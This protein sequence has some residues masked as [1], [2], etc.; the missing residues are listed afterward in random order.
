MDDFFVSLKNDGTSNSSRNTI[1]LPRSFE[2]YEF[3][4]MKVK[5]REILNSWLNLNPQLRLKK[6][7]NGM[8]ERNDFGE[9][10]NE[11]GIVLKRKYARNW[12]NS[13]LHENDFVPVWLSGRAEFMERQLIMDH[14][15]D[16]LRQ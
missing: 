4:N 14:H 7:K 16:Q 1:G 10:A 13:D 6:P 3:G 2:I 11:H 12:D 9:I 8:M 15:H 5:S